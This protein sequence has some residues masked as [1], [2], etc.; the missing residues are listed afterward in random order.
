[1]VQTIKMG[2]MSINPERIISQ[3]FAILFLS[4]YQ[5]RKKGLWLHVVIP[6]QPRSESRDNMSETT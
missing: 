4:P 5:G 1:V 3:C 2:I 6:S